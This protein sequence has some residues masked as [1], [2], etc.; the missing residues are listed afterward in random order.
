MWFARKVAGTACE[1]RERGD[2][3]QAPGA[4]AVRDRLLG[5]GAP[6]RRAQVPARPENT[7]DVRAD[8]YRQVRPRSTA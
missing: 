1:A 7:V 5:T 8:R 6:D 2:P 4:A 3:P